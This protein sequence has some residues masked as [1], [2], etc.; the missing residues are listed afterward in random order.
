MWFKIKSKISNGFRVY[1]I[2]VVRGFM[3][4]CLNKSPC[5]YVNTETQSMKTYC[6][7]GASSGIG[8]QLAQ[9]LA[10]EGNRVIATYHKH[11][12]QE[13]ISGIEYH[14]LNVLELP[15]SLPFLPEML[16]GLVYC[17][18][19]ISLRPFER[20]KASD[21]EQDYRLQVLGAIRVLQMAMPH[22][23]KA[24]QASVVLFSSIAAQSGLP[25]HSMV[26]SSKAA[27]EGL[28]KALAAEFAPGIRVNCIAPSLTQTPLAAALLNTDKKLEDN[29]QRHPLKRIGSA[30]DI[31]NMAQFLLSE[32]AAWI[33]GQ[34]MHVDGGYSSLKA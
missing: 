5:T 7:I 30:K 21:F 6:I 23:K 27:I 2:C 3:K 20:I 16:D 13:A 9:Q 25:F 18:G 33:S 11:E 31:A 34:V 14:A 10:A 8:K 26:A 4:A 12:P 24:E 22:L 28:S 15:D 19:S 1:G 29:A 32:K 17:P